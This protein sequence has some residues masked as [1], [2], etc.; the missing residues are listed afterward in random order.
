MPEDVPVPEGLPM[1]PLPLPSSEPIVLPPPKAPPAVAEADEMT[2]LSPSA[3]GRGDGRDWAVVLGVAA[4]AELM[5][6]WAAAC[7]GLW[8]RRLAW[9]RAVRSGG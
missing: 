8:R 2:L 7:V 1:L 4:I 6:V 5:L 3:L 9:T